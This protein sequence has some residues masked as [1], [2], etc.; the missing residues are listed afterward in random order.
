MASVAAGIIM[1]AREN[2]TTLNDLDKAINSIK[3]ASGKMIGFV[4]TD[5]ESDSVGYGRRGYGYGYGYGESSKK[6]G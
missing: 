2:K 4:L 5:V 6:N 1:V 3:M